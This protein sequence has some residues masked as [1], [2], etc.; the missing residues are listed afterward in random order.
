MGS[1]GGGDQKNPWGD[2]P[3]NQVDIEETIRQSK[4][5]IKK[6]FPGGFGNFGG[7]RSIGIIAVALFGLW[8]SSGFYFLDEKEQAVILQLGKY[9][10][11]T[12]AGLHYHFPYPIESR[13]V[14]NVSSIRTY[15][16]PKSL[17]LTGD[18]NIVNAGFS[19]QYYI[20]DLKNYILNARDPE[21]TL[22]IVS[23]SVFRDSVAHVDAQAAIAT[24][25]NR[26]SS[27]VKTSLQEL[28][29][30]YELGIKIT[31]IDL[32]DVDPPSPVRDAY[33]DVQRAVTD[34]E[35]KINEA[36]AY[37]NK[38]VEEAQG[39]AS[40]IRQSAKGYAV[41]RLEKARGE[42]GQFEQV[43]NSYRLAPDVTKKRLYIEAMQDILQ[44]SEKVIVD[45]KS[46]VLP[47]AALPA[48][49]NT[50]Q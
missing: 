20:S 13:I 22:K 46:G 45:S 1:K 23:V 47:H 43:Y 9:K 5:K 8:I 44:N 25:R 18:E 50:Q 2:R 27:E 10:E 33:L 34:K 48:F 15:N 17:V 37:R 16:V 40:R 24:D 35:N 19:V 7:G 31:Q 12:D 49:Q 36:E 6:A 32:Q 21:V 39:T 14:K 11:T 42:A 38:V 3:N 26:I 29:N 28:I 41:E 4:D 30:E